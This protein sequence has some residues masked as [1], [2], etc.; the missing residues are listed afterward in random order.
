MNPINSN[1]KKRETYTT[2][3]HE[4]RRFIIN[5]FDPLLG[6]YILVQV[7]TF[8]LPLGIGNAL[9]NAV[10]GSEVTNKVPTG[11]RMMSKDEFIQFQSDILGTIE[12][13]FESGNKSP[14]LRDNGTFGIA[15]V[16]MGMIT[17]LLIASLAFNFKD[18]FK[19]LPSIDSLTG[20]L[21]LN[22]VK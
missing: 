14:V 18:F 8:V 6:N 16:S 7:L 4:G 21:G 13:E 2:I 19:E 1:I 17:K 15:D 12:E 5:A 22:S 9:S 3:D 20:L 11:T 10:G